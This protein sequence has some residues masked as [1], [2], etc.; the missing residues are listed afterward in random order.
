MTFIRFSTPSVCILIAKQQ[1]PAAIFFNLKKIKREREK[2]KAPETKP[3]EN[4]PADFV[5]SVRL[6]ADR[7]SVVALLTGDVN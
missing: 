4:H 1:Q 7:C 5:T 3:D 2:K 6:L